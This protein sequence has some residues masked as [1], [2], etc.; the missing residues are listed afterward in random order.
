MHQFNLR[1][2]AMRLASLREL[3]GLSVAEMAA[4]TATTVDE[5]MECERGEKDF[6]FNFL[7]NCANKLG[8]NITELI[9]GDSGKLNCF[10]VTRKGGGMPIVRNSGYNYLHLA[11]NM[12]DRKSEPFIVTIPYSQEVENSPIEVSSHSGQELDHV[13]EGTIKAVVDGHETILHEGDT[14]YYNSDLK[15]GL[16]SLGGKDAVI[17]AVVIK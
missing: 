13:L 6:S 15:H 12:R 2:V 8:C 5:Y 3:V 1:E 10:T 14:I 9:T 7:Y 16:I 4:A 17:L 11:S